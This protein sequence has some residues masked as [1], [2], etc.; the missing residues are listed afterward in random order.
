MKGIHALS[1]S[2]EAQGVETYSEGANG[3]QRDIIQLKGRT[4]K[5]FRT[6]DE[7]RSTIEDVEEGLMSEIKQ[8]SDSIMLTVADLAEQTSGEIQVLNN[9]ISLRVTAAEVTSLIDITLDSIVLQ[10]DQ[11]NLNGYVSAG[12]GNFTIDEN[13]NL[14]IVNP[15][16]TVELGNSGLEVTNS[17]GQQIV[18]SGFAV[19]FRSNGKTY[20][21]I[22]L[23]PDTGNIN[24]S[25]PTNYGGKFTYNGSRVHTDSNFSLDFNGSK[26]NISYTSVGNINIMSTN[27]FIAESG[28]MYGNIASTGWVQGKVAAL[29]EAI[30]NL[31]NSIAAI[32]MRLTTLE[33][34][35][36]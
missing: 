8:T 7:M 25:I 2:Y 31:S 11:I 21:R 30:S 27:G 1:D 18:Y 15:S 35:V 16:H 23:N 28:Y 10:T 12:D 4:N 32:D 22:E 29:N 14:K 6:V 13:G 9:Q 24:V 26:T 20:G 33:A 19:W 5:L 3:I 36:V 17:D 34:K